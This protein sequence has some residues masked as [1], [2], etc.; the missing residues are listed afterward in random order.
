MVRHHGSHRLSWFG[1]TDAPFLVPARTTSAS[2]RSEG[3][4]R[5][6]GRRG[7]RA[8]LDPREPGRT[9]PLRRALTGTSRA[10]RASAARLLAL[11]LGAVGV[12]A[13][14]RSAWCGPQKEF[15]VER[16]IDDAAGRFGLPPAWIRAVVRAESDGHLDAVSPK[17]AM[18]LMQLMPGTWRQM[19][20]ELGLGDD[21]FAP[22]DNLLAGAAYLRRLY[23]AYGSR[24][25]LAAYNAGPGRYERHLSGEGELPA[26]T[27]RYVVRVS[28]EISGLGQARAPAAW[29]WRGASLFPEPTANG[30]RGLA[31]SRG[32]S[33]FV[34]RE[35][36]VRP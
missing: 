17:G 24:G 15:G 28:S 33:L 20:A 35:T 22:R 29:G 13:A 4:G 9:L 12:S 23:D 11:V 14:A 8:F 7:S 36:A 21:P 1:Q 27:V 5:P 26:E 34:D 31:V 30:A 10:R 6:P 2:A 18:G 25:F 16:A 19:R 3:Q 32:A